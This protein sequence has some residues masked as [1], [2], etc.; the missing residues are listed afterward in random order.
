MNIE[1]F[2]AEKGLERRIENALASLGYE[3]SLLEGIKSLPVRKSRALRRLGSYVSRSARPVEIRLQFALEEEKLV[4]TF[5]HE[6]AHCFDHLTN[7]AGTEY[8]IAHG[9]GWRNWALALGI[10]ANRCGESEALSELQQKE[11]KIVAVCSKCGFMLRRLRRLPRRRR[12]LHKECGGRLKP[13]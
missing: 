10:R 12:Y 7:Q 6:L 2:I 1:C 4:E 9:E 5:L 3:L 8:R 11:L 13:L